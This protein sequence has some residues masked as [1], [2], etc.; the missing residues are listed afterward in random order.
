[1]ILHHAAIWT[2]DTE[3]LKDF[4][5]RYLN[6]V[7][8]EKYINQTNGFESYFISFENGAKLE[9]MKKPGVRGNLSDWAGEQHTG[10]IHLAFEAG[11]AGEVDSKAIEFADAGIRVLRGPR[12]TGDGYYEF[13]A[14]D[15]DDNR[16]EVMYKL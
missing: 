15:P 1:M 3:V 16:I 6:G 2:T 9:I 14:L 13:E 4:Y 11:S 10:L 7:A 12:I 8:G 5:V